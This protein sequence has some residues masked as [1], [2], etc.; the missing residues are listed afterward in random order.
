MNRNLICSCLV[1]LMLGVICVNKAFSDVI[2]NVSATASSSND[3]SPNRTVD[4][5]GLTGDLHD[6]SPSNMWLSGM[7][8]PAPFIRY[9]LDQIYKV[10]EM[11]VWNYNETIEHF[12]GLGAKDVTI[13]YSINGSNWTQLSGA[14]QISQAPGQNGYAHN[15]TVDFGG[16]LARYVKITVNSG[17]GML[18]QYGLS[19]VRFFG[20]PSVAQSNLTISSTSGGSV[21]TPG[22]GSYTYDQGSSVSITATAQSEYHFVNWTGTA[23]TAGNV[24]NPNS[25]STTVTVDGDYTLR[26]NFAENQVVQ[27]TLTVSSSSGGSVTAPG[28]GSYTYD[29][30]TSV[31][32]TAAAQSNHHFV[33]WTGTAVAAGKV[34]NPNAASTTVTMDGDYTLRAIFEEDQV[35]CPSVGTY[36][37]DEVTET[38][39]RLKAYLANDGGERC[40]G[41]FRYWEKN[42]QARTMLSTSRQSSLHKS[43]QYSRQINDLLPGTTYCFQAVAENS[44]CRDESNTREFTTLVPPI[45]IIHVDDDAINDPGPVDLSISDPLEDGTLDHPYDS[46]QEAIEQAQDLD[47]V[48]VHE[49]TYY[50]VLNLMGKSIEIARYVAADSTITA[51]PIIDAHNQGTVVTVNQSEGSDCCLSGFVLTGGL[52]DRGSAIVCLGTSPTIRNC[53]IVGN[54]SIGL[55]GAVVY[56]ENSNIV[57]KNLTVHGN[58]AGA[59]G[60]SFCLLDSHLDVSNSVIW[61]EVVPHAFSVIS[62][63]DPIVDYCDVIGSHPG[64]GNLNQDPLFAL[65]GFWAGLSDPD[66]LPTGPDNPDA[67]WIHGDYHVLSQTGRWHPDNHSWVMDELTSPCIDAGDPSCSWAGEP[68]P[69]GVRI[70]MGAY[71]GTDQASCSL[72]LTPIVAL[73]TFDESSGSTAFDAVGNNH[74]T[75][76]GAVWT[77]GILDGALAFDGVDD[78]VDCGS[79]P[80]LAP[81]QFTVSL[82]IYPQATSRSRTILRKAGGDT[83]KDYDFELFAAR[84]PTFSFGDGTQSEV[85]Y[86]G[87]KLPLEQWTHVALTRDATEAAIYANGTRLV[88]Q[89]YGFIPLATN[90]KLIIGGASPQPFEGKIDDVAIYDSVLSEGD[91]ADLAAGVDL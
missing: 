72:Q 61:D 11:W 75:V 4:G 49:G 74:G 65:A 63:N 83:D 17:Y 52:N 91:I 87:S 80:A 84:Y 22:E 79:D 9:E 85:L 67:V 1:V 68:R 59:D 6:T 28:E 90:H 81:D 41:W 34:A 18:P 78:Y 89:T 25:A 37:A 46:I 62:G 12:I 8:D 40:E 27:H 31:S 48:L 10:E 23:V 60:S 3:T 45:R 58:F 35:G 43:Q 15:T 54:R 26:A 33:N 2:T 42:S 69:H 82:W 70:N 24:A 21:T 5:S 71:G 13:E 50:E 64:L 77:G 32:V 29:Q 39:A 20:D 88:N 19:E 36:E 86:S 47:K 16:A 14:P 38:S 56:C 51:Y 7:G 73:W 44:V 57:F 53:L 30:G 76:H 66:L 55:D